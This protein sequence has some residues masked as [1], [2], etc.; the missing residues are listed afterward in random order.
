[1]K[2]G[3]GG[4]TAS[5]TVDSVSIDAVLLRV[6]RGGDGGNR[7][8]DGDRGFGVRRHALSDISVPDRQLLGRRRRGKMLRLCVIVR[9]G[10]ARSGDAGEFIVVVRGRAA[11]SRYSLL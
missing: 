3:Y 11:L 6:R 10:D 5:P 7:F 1:V 4:T 2:D 8:L 9:L